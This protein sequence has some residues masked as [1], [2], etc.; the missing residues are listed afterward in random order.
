MIDFSIRNSPHGS[1]TAKQFED[2]TA[3]QHDSEAP[4]TLHFLFRFL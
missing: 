4:A 1:Q 2:Q 3:F